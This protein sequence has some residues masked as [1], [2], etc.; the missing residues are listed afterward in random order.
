MSKTTDIATLFHDL[1]AGI[2]AQR[3]DAAMRDVALRIQ[4]AEKVEEDIATDFHRRLQHRLVDHA[5][6]LI[7]TFTP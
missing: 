5:S 4:Q 6:L 3:L 1:D 7:G 2:F